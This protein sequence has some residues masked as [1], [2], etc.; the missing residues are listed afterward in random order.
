[1][2][3]YFCHVWFQH[4]REVLESWSSCYLFLYPSHHLGFSRASASWLFLS[5]LFSAHSCCKWR[6]LRKTTKP[7]VQLQ[8]W[9]HCPCTQIK[10]DMLCKSF[11]P[12]Q[13]TCSRHHW[14]LLQGQQHC[15]PLHFSQPSRTHLCYPADKSRFAESKVQTSSF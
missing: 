1:V 14:A 9:S 2:V 12:N 13:T 3:L 4:F 7:P 6:L 10:L 5:P 15:F 8:R 11:L